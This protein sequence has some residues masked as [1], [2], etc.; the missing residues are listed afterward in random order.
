MEAEAYARIIDPWTNKPVAAW[1]RIQEG[2]HCPDRYWVKIDDLRFAGAPYQIFSRKDYAE[3]FF[4]EH[5]RRLRARVN[6]RQK[7]GPQQRA[8]KYARVIAAGAGK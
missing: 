7:R 4:Y 2:K 3:E 5:T 6:Q 8:S 1:G